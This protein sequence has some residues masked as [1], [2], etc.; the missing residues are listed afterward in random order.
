MGWTLTT[1]GVT[2]MITDEKMEQTKPQINGNPYTGQ[3]KGEDLELDG[4]MK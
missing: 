2:Y 1:I 4:E 3:E